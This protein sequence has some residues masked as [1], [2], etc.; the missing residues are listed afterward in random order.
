MIGRI[1]SIW[2]T[3][4]FLAFSVAAAPALAQVVAFEA[5]SFPDREGWLRN[6]TLFPADRWIEDG[7]LVNFAEIVDP[8]PPE[9]VE[10]DSY[11]RSIAEFKLAAGSDFGLARPTPH[12]RLL[13]TD[14]AES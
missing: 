7:W 2:L 8:G 13:D 10:R 11:R 4:N 1:S 9:V 5:S 14:C 6:E 3:V 12:V